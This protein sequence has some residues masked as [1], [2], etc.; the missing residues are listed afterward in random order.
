MTG[1][2]VAW[3]RGGI[4]PRWRAWVLAA[5]A[6]LHLALP[7]VHGRHGA[8]ASGD[9]PHAHGETLVWS[10]ACERAAHASHTADSCVVCHHTLMATCSPAMGDDGAMGLPLESGRARRT[11]A[12]MLASGVDVSVH[13][14]RGPPA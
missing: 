3:G 5:A 7:L 2:R 9:G 11:P 10:A 1:G 13:G 6:A 8:I 12:P 4:G 14:P